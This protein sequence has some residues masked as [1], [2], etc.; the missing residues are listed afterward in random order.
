MQGLSF[1]SWKSYLYY[2]CIENGKAQT[3]VK[4]GDYILQ[5]FW[6]RG[7]EPTVKALIEDGTTH[8]DRQRQ[9]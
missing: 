4:L 7:I 3:F 8:T 6:E 2:D 1:E 5:I 9:P